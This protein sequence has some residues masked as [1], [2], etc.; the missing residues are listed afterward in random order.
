MAECVPTAVVRGE[1]SRT[2]NNTHTQGVV[3][4]YMATF[5]DSFCTGN[6]SKDYGKCYK[7]IQVYV[8]TWTTF[9]SQEHLKKKHLEHMKLVLQ[10]LVDVVYG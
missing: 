10:R 2:D 7:A 6:F 8:Y 4:I 1:E 9:S 3:P 5:Q